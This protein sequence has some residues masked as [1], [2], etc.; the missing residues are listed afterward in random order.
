MLPLRIISSLPGTAF[1]A[2]PLLD[3]C[4]IRLFPSVLEQLPT[5]QKQREGLQQ[6]DERGFASVGARSQ[7]LLSLG[8]L[9]SLLVLH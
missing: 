2:V 7:P 6:N 9:F 5:R 4:G 3:F 1:R 8:K